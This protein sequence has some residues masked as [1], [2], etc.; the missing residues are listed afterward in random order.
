MA[1]GCGHFMI[2]LAVNIPVPVKLRYLG[3]M[4]KVK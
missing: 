2:F 1:E 4:L 3:E